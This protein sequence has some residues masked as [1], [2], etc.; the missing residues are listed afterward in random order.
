M[1]RRANLQQV[2]NLK[3]LQASA[4]ARAAERAAGRDSGAGESTGL[5]KSQKKRNR[6]KKAKGGTVQ[7]A[8][9]AVAETESSEL[10]PVDA[11][12]E[13]PQQLIEFVDF[14]PHVQQIIPP[15]TALNIVENQ[16]CSVRIQC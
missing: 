10:E 13:G 15:D 5:T 9:Q 4:P 11:E 16:L 12:P 7:P 14:E 3:Q 1:M 8:G 2:P 6:K